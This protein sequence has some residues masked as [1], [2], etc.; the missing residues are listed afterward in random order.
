MPEFILVSDEEDVS[1]VSAAA[2][3][4]SRRV[5][6]L[7]ESDDERQEP[8]VAKITHTSALLEALD[9]HDFSESDEPDEPKEPIPKPAKRKRAV[10]PTREA[11]RDAERARKTREKEDAKLAK[12][13][14]KADKDINKVSPVIWPRHARH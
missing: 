8:V 10:D 4:S 3:P 5:H 14:A 1:F 6:V 13:R 2:G 11:E 12:E 7:D 9:R